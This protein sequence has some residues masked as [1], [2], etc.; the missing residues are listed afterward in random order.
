M[1]STTKL[2]KIEYEMVSSKTK[3]TQNRTQ[4]I[5]DFNNKIGEC[6]TSIFCD[7][8]LCKNKF[9]IELNDGAKY[10]EG[11]ETILFIS[12]LLHRIQTINLKK[13]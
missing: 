7:G 11:C 1:E 6:R 5:Y 12:L 4:T 8:S 10:N 13:F 3:Q 2:S 9:R